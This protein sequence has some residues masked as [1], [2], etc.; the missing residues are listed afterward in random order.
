VAGIGIGILWA[1]YLL[2]WWGYSTITNNSNGLADL[3]VPGHW[4]KTHPNGITPG[5]GQGTPPPANGTAPL[6]P[7]AAGLAAR[8]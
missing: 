6:S 7:S 8:S 1:G 4:A 5:G 3:A 2:I